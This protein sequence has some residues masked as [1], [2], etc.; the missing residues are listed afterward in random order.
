MSTPFVAL[1]FDIKHHQKRGRGHLISQILVSY[2]KASIEAASILVTIGSCFTTSPSWSMQAGLPC[3]LHSSKDRVPKHGR[4][5]TPKAL[6]IPIPLEKKMGKSSQKQSI[7]GI[8]ACSRS[9]GQKHPDRPTFGS[10]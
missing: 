1:A 2:S 4:N 7:F 10:Y 8:I 5:S 9:P 3:L 6:Y